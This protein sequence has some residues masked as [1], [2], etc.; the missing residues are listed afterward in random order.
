MLVIVNKKYNKIA[1][2]ST[3]T[4]INI[5]S[6]IIINV[7]VIFVNINVLCCEIIMYVELICRCFILLRNTY[8]VYNFKGKIVWCL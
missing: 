6:S 8:F 4:T 7:I 3:Q 2:I 1:I 5:Y